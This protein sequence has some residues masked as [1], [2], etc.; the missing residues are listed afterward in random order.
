MR[1]RGR[2][3]ALTGA[4]LLLALLALLPA[5]A[6]A[7]WT[8]QTSTLTAVIITAT[9]CP[10]SDTCVQIN[11]SGKVQYTQ[12]GGATWNAS[13]ATALSGTTYG[14]DCPST[15]LCFAT[16][17][18]GNI[19]KSINL[20]VSWTTV[21]TGTPALYGISCPSTMICYAVSGTG[22]VRKTTDGGGTWPVGSTQTAGA[23]MFSVSCPSTTVCYSATAAGAVYKKQAANDTWSQVAT[24]AQISDVISPYT[25]TVS[26]PS[27]LVCF[28]GGTDGTISKTSNG[29]ANWGA[30]TSGGTTP[31]IYA[32]S[33]ASETRC[34]AVGVANQ[35]SFTDNGTTWSTATT[36]SAAAMYS[37]TW[38]GPGAAFAGD[39]IGKPYLYSAP[40]PP[41][42]DVDVSETLNPG[43]LSF[44][45]GTPG[46][47]TFPS[48][49]LTNANQTVT[50]TQPITVADATGSGSGW[51]IDVTST[52]FTTGTRTL[53]NNATIVQGT[54][55]I[56][57][58]ASTTCT[59]ATN[60]VTYPFSLPAGGTAPP[61]AKLYNA[62][63]DT[64]LGAQTITPTWRL[65]VP[66]TAY[67]GTYTSTWTYTLTA[68][69]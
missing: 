3:T 36:G 65:T 45:D 48:T 10:T 50:A 55:S 66:A 53:A 11:T 34:I 18:N 13:P 28:V 51:S 12:N 8:G 19:Y 5:V 27:L 6:Q 20:G 61:A 39:A 35:S 63:V 49:A 24:A 69:P 41:D 22:A 2:R 26:C 33:C 42:G 68:G 25:Q 62:A 1:A 29:G 57:C 31:D 60:S 58:K 23:G 40:Q 38:A 4:A 7:A 56:A 17:V 16:A 14:M 64:G 59:P 46:N 30:V 21:S 67:T 37:I 52:T 15:T 43:S 54:P 47:V 32:L 9:S 44:I